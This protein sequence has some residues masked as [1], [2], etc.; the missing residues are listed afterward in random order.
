MRRAV[1]SLGWWKEIGNNMYA[2]VSFYPILM[3]FLE[4]DKVIKGLDGA[5]TRAVI[6]Y[7]L[8]WLLIVTGKVISNSFSSR[9]VSIRRRV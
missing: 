2:A 8:M 5:S 1:R 9:R 6:I 4:L 3:V 7:G